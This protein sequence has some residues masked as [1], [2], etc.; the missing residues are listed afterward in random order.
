[1]LCIRMLARRTSL[2]RQMTSVS[3]L[4][5][6]ACPR[7]D[8]GKQGHVLWSQSKTARVDRQTHLICCTLKTK[9]S[10]SGPR[11]DI[12]DGVRY[13]STPPKL[14]TVVENRGDWARKVTVKRVPTHRHRPCGP[15]PCKNPLMTRCVCRTGSCSIFRRGSDPKWW[16]VQQVLRGWCGISCLLSY[17]R[18]IIICQIDR[19]F[20]LKGE[21]GGCSFIS[22]PSSTLS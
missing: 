12:V 5:V 14:W 15:L 9:L 16:S 13:G 20:S 11:I 3:C 1:M 10:A 18:D 6:N 19:P 17:S 4:D 8:H 21:N 22:F 7:A 2:S